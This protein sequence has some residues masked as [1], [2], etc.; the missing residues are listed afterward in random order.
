ME[1]KVLSVCGSG[2]ATSTLVAERIKEG[3][4]ERGIENLNICECNVN[5]ANSKIQSFAPDLVVA[6]TSLESVNLNGI[7]GFSGIPILLN[8]NKEDLLDKMYACLTGKDK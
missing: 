2:I 6:T 4:R 5:E 3:L 1:Y 7:P 8:Q